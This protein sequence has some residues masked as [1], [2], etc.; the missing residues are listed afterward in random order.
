MS[1]CNSRRV[2]TPTRILLSS[3]TGYSHWPRLPCSRLTDCASVCAVAVAGRATTLVRM[4]SR[5]NITSRGST[6]YS[7]LRC[8]PRRLIFSVTMERRSSS[9]VQAC[10]MIVVTSSGSSR[11]TLWVSSTAK[12]MA[13]SG[14]PS[15]PARVADMVTTA[16]TAD[17]GFGSND[18][19]VR[20]RLKQRSHA[21]EKAAGRGRSHAGQRHRHQAARLPLEEQQLH[22]QQHC[23]HGRGKN[24]GHAGG[25]TGHQQSLALRISEVEK[26]RDERAHGA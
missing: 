1:F 18:S 24:R 14:A 13:V 12:M 10:A 5:M 19:M 6:A 7:R 16:Q 25:R 20:R 4:T 11:L 3:M 22:R 17:Q 2:T 23:R 8:R 26:L 21:D 9:A 15:A